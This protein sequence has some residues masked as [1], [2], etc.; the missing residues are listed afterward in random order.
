MLNV[1][2]RE[3]PIWACEKMMSPGRRL[4]RPAPL[5]MANSL[6]LDTPLRLDRMEPASDMESLSLILLGGAKSRAVKVPDLRSIALLGEELAK[7][8]AH[9]VAGLVGMG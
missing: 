3:S 4:T 2:F 8:E 1:G 5:R 9:V 7:G 6:T